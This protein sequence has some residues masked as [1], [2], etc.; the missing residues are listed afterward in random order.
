MEHII[1]YTYLLECKATPNLRLKLFLSRENNAFF[2]K[3]YYNTQGN[4]ERKENYLEGL[5]STF[6]ILRNR[7]DSN[8]GCPVLK[9][10]ML[11]LSC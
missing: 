2:S 3:T 1:C 9:L 4:F 10:D 8:A 11:P 7:I 5:H 6:Q